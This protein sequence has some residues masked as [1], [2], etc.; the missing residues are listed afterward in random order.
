MRSVDPSCNALILTSFDDD[1]ALFAAIMAGA[2]G[3]VLKDVRAATCSAAIKQVAGASRSS[4]P[5]LMNRVLERVRNGPKVA[6]EL[7]SLSEQEM[8]LLGH[9]AEG[10]DEP[11]DQRAHVPGGEDGEEL[12]VDPAREAGSG[13]V[14]PRPRCSRRG[15]CVPAASDFGPHGSWPAALMPVW[16]RSHAGGVAQP[17]SG[18]P[19][20]TKIEQGSSRTAPTVTTSRTGRASPRPPRYQRCPRGPRAAADRRSG[21]TF[22]WAFLDKTFALGFHTGYDEAGE[23][24]PVRRRRL[25]QRRQPHRGV[26]GFG[27]DGPFK[28]LLQLDRRRRLGRLAV[29]ARSARHRRR[30]HPRHLHEAGRGHRRAAL[31]ADVDRRPASRRTTP[32]GRPHPRGRHAGRPRLILNAG[33]TWG[34]GRRWGA[35]GIVRDNPVLR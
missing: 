9:V 27:A 16:R 30:A 31:R 28:E 19:G 6:P 21:W 15:C 18:R 2:M 14:V 5:A 35:T 23:P 17:A 20:R 3:Y 25:D 13:D 29:H 7:E 4:T 26:P 8:R 10:L 12:R 1:E 32:S 22:L 24:G 33:D 34:F 11:P